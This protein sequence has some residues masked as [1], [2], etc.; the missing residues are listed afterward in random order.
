MEL[1]NLPNQGVII[2]DRDKRIVFAD[3][4]AC[5]LLQTDAD[6]LI[7]KHCAEVR[8]IF[9]CAEEGCNLSSDCRLFFNDTPESRSNHLANFLSRPVNGLDGSQLG[10]VH[11]VTLSELPER[12]TKREFS[13][14]NIIGSSPNMKKL[15]ELIE[16][17]SRTGVTVHISGES[18]TGKELV[19]EA[20][21]NLSE[22]RLKRLVKVNCSSIAPTLLESSLFG[23]VKG[24]F[25]GAHKDQRGF[26]EHA[27]GGTLFLDEIGDISLDI[28]VKL[29]RLLQSRE[30]QRVGE[31]QTRHIDLRIITAT[32]Q[33]LLSLVEKGKMREDFYYRINVFPVSIPPL[34]QRLEDIP[35][36]VAH[37]VQLFNSRF[38]KEILG[39]AESALAE[40]SSYSWPGNV[41][42]LEHAVEHAFV[43]AAN[44]NLQSEHFPNYRSQIL[45]S[46]IVS[47][48]KTTEPDELKIIS[49]LEKHNGKVALAA[50]SL[51]YSRVT[52]WKKMKR[53]GISKH[54]VC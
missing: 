15:F 45:N 52:L 37:F 34:R 38:S 8:S 49:A 44:G 30:Y 22:R 18:G 36:L 25:T 9:P 39:V 33:N 40:L 10:L 43:K 2:V 23:H 31:S 3:Y 11:I 47:E 42:E 5:H 46:S 54:S 1:E 7:G 24:A 48:I 35:D 14:E 20:I 6:N 26:V 21:H 28:Q 50:K 32:N 16:L 12:S 51:G 29:L 4:R 53:L 27:D 19:A 41:R 13:F 17:V